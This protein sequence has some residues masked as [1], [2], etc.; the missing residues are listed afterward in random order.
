MTLVLTLNPS[1]G[2]DLVNEVQNY[3]FWKYF[4]SNYHV[5]SGSR[6]HRPSRV[7]SKPIPLIDIT[8]NVI[9]MYIQKKIRKATSLPVQLACLTPSQQLILACKFVEWI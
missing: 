3:Y 9:Y 1:R 7:K 4:N 8:Q 5:Y 2:R 6:L